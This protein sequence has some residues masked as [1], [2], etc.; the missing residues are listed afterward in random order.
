MIGSEER[1][2][3]PQVCL[4]AFDCLYLNGEALTQKPLTERRAALYSAL[5]EKEGELM[6][7]STKVPP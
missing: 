1:D 5:S 3:G 2:S 4:Y 6:W 7:A